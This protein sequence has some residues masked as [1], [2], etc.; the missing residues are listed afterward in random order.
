VANRTNITA[1]AAGQAKSAP[2][3]TGSSPLIPPSEFAG[4]NI[5]RYL[6][7]GAH[8]PAL[9]AVTEAVAWGHR[10]QSDGPAGRA[11]LF[12]AEER[13]RAS[14]GRLAGCGAADVGLLGDASTAW[15]AVAN[16]LAWEPGD[17]VVVNAFEH[18]ANV[19]PWLRLKRRGLE[20]RV[21]EHDTSWEIAPDAIERACDGR[22][23]ALVVSQVGYVS[24]YRHDAR[25]LSDIADRAGVPLLVD[26][27]HGLGVVPFDVR[28]CHLAICA[29]YK[30]LLGP[31]GVGIVLWNR[32]RLPDFEPGAVGW[33]ST[34][35]IFTPDRFEHYSVAP[36]A[37]RF[38]LGA[39]SLAAIAGLGAA[40]DRLLELPPGAAEEHAL[41][42]S[43][44]AIRLLR[45]RELEVTTPDDPSRRAGNVAF[46]HPKGE[47][48]ADELAALGVPVWGGDGRVRASFHAMNDETALDALGAALHAVHLGEGT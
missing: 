25:A 10:V 27:S 14:I 7:T 33:R 20:V 48:V 23:R 18:P 4:S 28:D 22:T 42:L 12:D 30:W 35:D 34:D 3:P 1:G 16:G 44:R 39:P 40:V 47:R 24:G 15:N 32:E 26:V 17:N 5:T 21:V 13:T 2:G 36:D 6:Y 19:L 29:S 11:A 37:R 8:A 43:A 31:Y 41:D 46:L 45:E 38:Q 9:T